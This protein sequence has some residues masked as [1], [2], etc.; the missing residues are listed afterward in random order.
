MA[1]VTMTANSDLSTRCGAVRAELKTWEKQ[2]AAAN[3]GRKAGRG[4]IKV[5]ASIA[6]KYKEYNKLRDI[7]DG[8]T[9][10]P[11]KPDQPASPKRKAS[12]TLPTSET[13]TKKVKTASSIP[14]ATPTRH[15]A[16]RPSVQEKLLSAS[17]LFSPSHAKLML[18]PTPQKDGIVLGIFDLLPTESPS[19]PRTVLGDIEAN[20][21]RTPQKATSSYTDD[22]LLQSG[23][24]FSRTPVSE[25]KRNFLDQFATPMK[26]K[27]GDEQGTP[28]SRGQ[29]TPMFLRRDF[30]TLE[31]VAEDVPLSPK[32]RKPRS[33]I[34]SFSTILQERKKEMEKDKKKEQE[35]LQRQEAQ[36]QQEEPDYD[37]DEEALRELEAEAE[38]LPMPKRKATDVL[39]ADSQ[40]T[41]KL[42]ADG[43]NLS[44][45]DEA[46][47]AENDGQQPRKAWKKRGQKRQTKRVIMRPVRTRPQSQ[48]SAAP[49]ASDGDDESAEEG[50]EV[51]D[52]ETSVVPETQLQHATRLDQDDESD[53]ATIP[54]GEE[55]DHGSDYDDEAQASKKKPQTK[56]ETT[57]TVKSKTNGAQK[58]ENKEENI[59]KKAA[60][61]IGATAHANFRRLKIKNKNSRAGGGGGRWGRSRR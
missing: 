49:A 28:S 43:E 32:P 23:R 11:S 39:V 40:A 48:P 17:K 1:T 58:E 5:N 53:S 31:T 42:G 22:E 12:A 33:F 8:K 3:G 10:A 59:V 60:R 34:R 44:D 20:T 45:T 16:N 27:R 25:G 29:A 21:L 61:K 54:D 41:M 38:D 52:D 15:S 57:T 9:K 7:L 14:V 55:L 35:E 50:D 13:P 30:R 4:D 18:G 26:R 47:D 37:D 51:H 46:S 36:R 6:S 24:L 2:F 56:P 19:K